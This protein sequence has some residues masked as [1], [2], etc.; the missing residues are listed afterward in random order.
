MDEKNM[1]DDLVRML[2]EGMAQGM[3]HVRM[4][5]MQCALKKV[6]S[7][8][9]TRWKELP[10][11]MLPKKRRKE[12]NLRKT[13]RKSLSWIRNNALTDLTVSW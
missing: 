12:R 11:K 6:H 4:Q 8:R 1:I 13:C 2:D 9:W 3:G 5:R 10:K 7:K